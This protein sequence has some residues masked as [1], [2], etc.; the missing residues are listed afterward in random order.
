MRSQTKLL[1]DSGGSAACGQE[2]FGWEQ[3]GSAMDLDIP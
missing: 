2:S 1:E 3:K